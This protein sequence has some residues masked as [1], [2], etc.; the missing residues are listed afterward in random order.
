MTI[1]NCSLGEF[2]WSES[3]EH[4]EVFHQ[5]HL[6]SFSLTLPLM[7]SNLV[8]HSSPT[9]VCVRMCNNSLRTEHTACSL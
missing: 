2:R 1:P 8:H 6:F 9:P 3:S 7:V 4:G 5:K